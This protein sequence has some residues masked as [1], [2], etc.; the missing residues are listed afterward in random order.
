M[1]AV[2]AESDSVL[3]RLVEAGVYPSL[4]AAVAADVGALT[5]AV[6]ERLTTDL[7]VAGYRRTPQ[8]DDEV[9][10]ARAAGARAIAAE[11]W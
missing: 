11:P 10:V 2:R 8:T 6:R 4:D 7:I 5:H 1:E 9:A 3:E